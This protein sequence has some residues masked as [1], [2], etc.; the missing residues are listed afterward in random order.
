M[1]F[2]LIVVAI[3]CC[4]FWASIDRTMKNNETTTNE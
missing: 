4:A 1:V 2:G 3:I